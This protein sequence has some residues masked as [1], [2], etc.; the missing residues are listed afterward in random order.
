MFTTVKK[1]HFVGIGGI[2]MSG[3]AEILLSQGFNVSGSDMNQS[4][5]TDYLI[6][7]GAEVHIGHSEKN[8]EGAEVV[9]YSS[10]V[11][12]N[13]NPETKLAL[14][15]NIPVIRRAEM[16]AE[17]SRLNYCIGIA[18]THGK[19]TTTSMI[20]LILIEAEIDP[21]VLVG[22]RLQDFGGTNARLGKGKWIVVE[23]DEYDRSFLQL[24]PTIA[25][26]NNIEADHLDIY[27][28]INDIYETFKDF[29]NKVPF[30]GLVA[31]CLDDLGCKEIYSSINKKIATYGF[32]RHS[33]IRGEDAQYDERRSSCKVYKGGEYL[34]IIEIGMPGKHN[35]TNALAATTVALQMGVEF[36][37]IQKALKQF[38]GVFRRFENKGTYKNCLVI[39]DYGHHPSEVKA[40]LEAAQK[41][42]NKKVICIFQPHTYSRTQEMAEEFGMS[43]DNADK[44]IV[45]DV[46]PAR[47][48]PIEGVTG[49]LIAN[50]AR[51]YGHRNVEYVSDNDELKTVLDKLIDDEYV[52]LTVGAGNIFKFAELLVNSK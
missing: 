37:I 48:L 17:L 3:I 27:S 1:I 22:G 11:K 25:V 51:N 49:E 39:D 10:A 45:T 7:L 28:D 34:G 41:G 18:G 52:I 8:I 9:V 6:K 40:T 47:E 33:M 16:L 15:K 2:G 24:T 46:Y 13:E 29:A 43:F 4:E 42:W 20:S 31:L 38:N 50:A 26:V 23:A 12:P 32:S 5:N 36:T 21:T 14:E 19:T 44:L 30:Y 35:L